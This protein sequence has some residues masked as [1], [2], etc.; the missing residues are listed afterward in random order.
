MNSELLE[1]LVAG[2]DTVLPDATSL[3][4]AIH[5]DPHLGGDEGD[6]RDAFT[7]ATGWLD[8]TP[9]AETGAYTR[10]G[11]DGPA[12][13][14]RAE[15]DAL[16]LTEAT[17]VEWAS[18]RRGIMHACGHDVHLA[19]L[20][21]VLT[22]ARDLDLPAAMVPVLQPREEENPPGAGDVVA[23]GALEDADVAA[24]V[25]V[26]VQ[27]QV[28]RGVVSTGSGAVNAAFDSFEITVR[29]RGGHGAYP[30][31]ALDPITVL[32]AI[33]TGLGELPM[34]VI[35]PI[36]P[37]VVSV[38]TFHAGTAANVIAETAACT[39]SI[40]TFHEKDRA[41]LHE[42]IAR[43][44][45]GTAMARGATATATF[46]RGGPALVNDADLA[47][48]A[49]AL[50]AG[51][52]VPVAPVPF[53]SCGSDDFSEYGQVVPSLMSFIGVGSDGG[54][55]LHHPE[56]L[57]GRSALRLAAIALAANYAAAA[58]LLTA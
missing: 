46:V 36:H 10:T 47:Q 56:F 51:L 8:W 11:P 42:A 26:H 29:G 4:R 35:N 53:R 52:N 16:P 15:L 28:E 17:G 55:G 54:V 57:P 39:G 20:W 9:V 34:R 41:A 30:H 40:R 48:R 24:M 5:A 33:V 18:Q 1:A 38:G 44:A 7:E 27:P 45:E 6:T 23:S 2:I 13:G 37:S 12:V 43:L 14:L 19:A 25:G 58:D 50:L 21:A 32:S 3:R 22:A 31:T 49:D